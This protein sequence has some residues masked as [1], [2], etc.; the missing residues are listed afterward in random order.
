MKRLVIII[1]TIVYLF[2]SH[3]NV[4]SMPHNLVTTPI[5]GT[6]VALTWEKSDG[7]LNYDIWMTKNG[8]TWSKVNSQAVT[9]STYI[10]GNGLI[11]PWVNYYFLV[12]NIGSVQNNDPMS[13]VD[14]VYNAT[15]ISIAFPPGQ[16][17]HGSYK[18]NTNAC[19]K[20][21]RTHTAAGPKLLKTATVNDTCITCH[22]GTGSKYNVFTGAVDA[23]S[24]SL[25]APSG[26]FGNIFNH[27]IE[28][29]EAVEIPV[30]SIHSVDD[31]V[32]VGTAP[33]VNTSE[34]DGWDKPFGCGNCHDAH[35]SYN[36]RMLAKALPGNPDVT[37][38]AFAETDKA[39]LQEKVNY[40]LGMNDFC[41]G[42][43]QKYYTTQTG[44][45]SET[46][47]GETY[48]HPVGIAPSSYVRGPLTTTLVLEGSDPN[49]NNNN[50]MC[51][52]CHNAHGSNSLT[53]ETKAG[54]NDGSNN[55]VNHLLKRDNR[56]VC[57]DCHKK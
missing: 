37:V 57:Q 56:A 55:E 27:I 14:I 47:N 7:D 4:F 35:G 29:G 18:N 39:N 9:G 34:G 23:G 49:H 10:V 46:V 6:E 54:D 24:Q 30:K 38:L 16:T 42:C 1:S 20:C 45:G 3:H 40:R 13:S 52:T 8:L 48:M 5:S 2:S 43:H 50:M 53:E 28:N 17:A 25:A 31:G 21:H 19:A 44:S 32:L 22:D 15:A 11:E 33:G 36:Y 12:S 41:S 26:P 51:A